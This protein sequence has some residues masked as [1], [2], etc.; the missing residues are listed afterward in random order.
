MP[1]VTVTLVQA[2]RHNTWANMKL[3]EAIATA[4][5]TPDQLLSSVEGTYGGLGRTLVHII[6][7]E[8]GYL[9]RLTG[10]P[11]PDELD[12]DQPF[13]GF[14]VLLDR[15]RQAGR[16]LESFASDLTEDRVIHWNR[17][18]DGQPAQ[19]PASLFLVQT[20]NH[21]NEHRSQVATILTQAGVQPPELDGWGYAIE[22]GEYQG[23]LD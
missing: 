6:G 15:A 19:M 3:I 14:E 17:R 8:E 2:L 1:A 20:I 7:A 12:E 21:G 9:G 4:G 5:L 16:E 13:P 18:L 22:T 23:P 10:E 11:R